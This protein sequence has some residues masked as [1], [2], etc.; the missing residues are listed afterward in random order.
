MGAMPVAFP[1][2]AADLGAVGTDEG[3]LPHPQPRAEEAAEVAGGAHD[4]LDPLTGTVLAAVVAGGVG[5]DAPDAV[6]FHT[7]RPP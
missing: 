1:L 7:K 4:N 6:L 5:A 2:L 3:A